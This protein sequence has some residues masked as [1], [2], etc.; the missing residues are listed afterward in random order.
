[1]MNMGMSQQKTKTVGN[2]SRVESYKY[3]NGRFVDTH[4]DVLGQV[5]SFYL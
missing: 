1:M 5:E 3:V 2:T 4:T